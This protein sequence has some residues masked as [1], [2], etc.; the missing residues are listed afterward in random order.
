MYIILKFNADKVHFVSVYAPDMSKSQEERQNFFDQLQ[1][2]LNSFPQNEKI[3][4]MGDL[5]SRIGNK[6]IPGVVQ[7]FNEEVI[8]NNGEML[9]ALCAQNELRINNTY[10]PHKQQYKYTFSNTR[11]QNSVIDYVITNK[12]V[13]P[14]H[15]LD[16]RVLTSANI[17]S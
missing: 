16:V 11:N 7:R 12:K 4:I 9:I 14:A 5:N 1:D 10:F 6:P 8:N 17:G 2:C 15:I 3:F 13:N